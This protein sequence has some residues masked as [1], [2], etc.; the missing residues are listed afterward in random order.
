MEQVLKN[1]FLTVTLSSKGGELTSAVGK[2]GT[3]YVWTADPAFWGQHA[4]I[5]FPF[6]GRLT[7]GHYSLDGVERPMTIHGYFS[8]EELEIVSASDT[9]VTF[10]HR[11]P[12]FREDNEYDR[13]YEAL[14]TYTLTG[15]TLTVGF[16]VTNQ[17]DRTMYFGYGGHPGFNVPLADGLK[18]T[19]YYLEFS[20]DCVP[21]QIGFSPACYL[22]GA[23]VPLVLE[24]DRR[25]R[26]NHLLF[27]HDAI[28][29]RNMAHEVTLKTDADSHGVTLT[30][31]KMPYLGV[32]HRPYTEAPY[33]CIEPWVSLP[34]RQDIVEKFEE[35]R[36]LVV[37]APGRTYRNDWQIRFF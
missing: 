35:R 14:L 19:D 1:E 16:A 6:D 24:G 8:S 21:A 31:P 11:G 13:K 36:D 12:V 30:F 18:F 22:Q 34:S 10:R 28:F 7:N 25:L 33:V 17:D 20:E 4:P 15:D 3:E 37:L 27:N 5:L 29:M 9:L 2:D 32:W 26:L 23:D